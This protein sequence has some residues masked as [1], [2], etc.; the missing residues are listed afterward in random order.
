MWHRPS[1]LAL[2]Q[3]GA[4]EAPAK[5]SGPLSP[6]KRGFR[7]ERRDPGQRKMTRK[8]DSYGREERTEISWGE[9]FHA[10]LKSLSLAGRS[11]KSLEDEKSHNYS[12]SAEGLGE[13][14]NHHFPY[15]LSEKTL[16]A[17]AFLKDILCKSRA[18]RGYSYRRIL[19]TSEAAQRWRGW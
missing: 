8:S 10:G 3:K 9:G 4:G 16:K 18:R 2:K 5:K 6:E 15:S 1:A 13:T 19:G 17:T 12:I 11:L 14:E 7:V